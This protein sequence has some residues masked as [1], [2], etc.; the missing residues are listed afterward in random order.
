MRVMSL[1]CCIAQ[2]SLVLLDTFGIFIK[3]IINRHP[4][5]GHCLA[6]NGLCEVLRGQRGRGKGRWT[7]AGFLCHSH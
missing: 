4:L 2:S 3:K 6:V 1:V 5:Y 7:P